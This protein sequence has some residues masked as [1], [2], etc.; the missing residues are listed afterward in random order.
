MF[1]DDYVVLDSQSVPANKLEAI[2]RHMHRVNRHLVDKFGDKDKFE[3]YLRE[4]VDSDKNG[5]I[6][7]DE[8]KFLIKDCLAEEVISRRLT[9][10]DLEGFLSAF[11]YNRHGATDISTIA[12]MVF[13]KDTNK[14]TVAL[15]TKT[16]ANPPPGFVNMDLADQEGQ[17]I[18]DEPQARRL[19]G[20]L[21]KIE[22]VAFTGGKPK[23]FEV[24]RAFDVDG[25]GFV[26]YKDF[27]NHLVKNKV[28]ASKED[29]ASLMK[30]VLD[31]DGNGYIDF[32]T[33]KEKF[34]PN[35]S[36]LVE[37]PE[38]EVHLPNLVPNQAKLQEYG[39]R[40]KGFRTSFA[41]VRNRFA[42]D[43]NQSK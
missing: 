14:L 42:P 43:E 1:N 2:E 38:N 22:D 5:N 20:L 39:Q 34:G 26:S 8:F 30:H 37:V 35:M 18:Q 9:K 6:S 40:A 10:K 24:F 29:I 32:N 3:T 41:D 15:S 17:P 25:D 31:T 13:E 16:R 7:V 4:K 36:K 28:H 19:R 23:A 11:K 21:E 27:E 33:F 12:P